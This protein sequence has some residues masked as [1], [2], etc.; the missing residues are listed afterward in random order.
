MSR[1]R[2]TRKV[3]LFVLSL[4]A[5]AFIALFTMDLGRFGGVV[6]DFVSARTDF[7]IEF[8]GNLSARLG[9]QLRISASDVHLWRDGVERELA[10]IDNLEL[11]LDTWTLLGGGVHV[12]DLRLDDADFVYVRREGP[13]DAGGSFAI[14][15]AT[16]TRVTL[17]FGVGSVSGERTAKIDTLELR[18]SASEPVR[19]DASG[20]L[21]GES[22]RASITGSDPGSEEESSTSPITALIVLADAELEATGTIQS[23]E[24][25]VLTDFGFDFS[26]PDLREFVGLFG[27]GKVP[28]G[29]FRF[30][31]KAKLDHTALRVESAEGH[32]GPLAGTASGRLDFG[33]LS[34]TGA[35]TGPD[36]AAFM[37]IWVNLFLP[38]EPFSLSGGLNYAFA[39]GRFAFEQAEASIE[40]DIALEIDGTLGNFLRAPFDLTT[41]DLA[42]KASGPRLDALLVTVPEGVLR[43]DIPYDA[44]GRVT[45]T[46]GEVRIDEIVANVAGANGTG[47]FRYRSGEP[48]TVHVDA[49][50]D[51][52]NPATVFASRRE[53]ESE[54]WLPDVS[55]P[56]ENFDAF[57]LEARLSAGQLVLGPLTA[58]DTSATLTMRDRQLLIDDIDGT[59]RRGRLTGS[60]ALDGRPDVAATT[61]ELVLADAMW[62]EPV[63][64]RGEPV[65]RPVF[66]ASARVTGNGAS[67]RDALANA[68]GRIELSETSGYITSEPLRKLLTTINPA[69]ADEPA[70]LLE[71]MVAHIDIADGVARSRVAAMATDTN[72]IVANGQ[73]D[74]GNENILLRFRIGAA[75]GAVNLPKLFSPFVQIGGTLAQP[76]VS[77]QPGN[78]AALIVT[79]GWSLLFSVFDQL[80]GDDES[81]C[82]AAI[83]RA[84]RD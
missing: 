25:S 37:E 55:F 23:Q 1:T 47:T 70:I 62:E 78:T 69:V 46:D 58:Q 39:D 33:G 79:K 10:A 32:V 73:L 66:N 29:E 15:N 7:R 67:L 76:A 18:R 16:I 30:S 48:P 52:L 24:G 5:L 83:R 80:S 45:Y 51:T 40:G 22:I 2:L 50:V 3:V 42:V 4:A 21:A 28:A 17:T 41:M 53:P 19:L 8:R 44:G 36:A 38:A 68:S 64:A 81:V 61:A 49:A 12:R 20:S 71:C 31:G 26:G 27:P 43:D 13:G 9:R 60:V 82:E 75:D 11:A 56:V 77:L 6:E 63:D 14:D 72:E 35:V 84:E 54:R 59:F 74:L 34:L 65:E 57:D